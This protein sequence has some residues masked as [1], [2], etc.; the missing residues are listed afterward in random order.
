MR[1][2]THEANPKYSEGLFRSVKRP[3]YE[4]KDAAWR[5]PQIDMLWGRKEASAWPAIQAGKNVGLFG[6]TGVGKSKMILGILDRVRETRLCIV[7][8]P[9]LGI[10]NNF[11]ETKTGL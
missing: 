10:L 4:D 2:L 5:E 1:E 6:P 11:K 3:I 9:K 7:S 8:T